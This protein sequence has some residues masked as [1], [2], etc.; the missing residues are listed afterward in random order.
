MT[1]RYDNRTLKAKLEPFNLLKEV[2][3]DEIRK[4]LT[5]ARNKVPKSARKP[6]NVIKIFNMLKSIDDITNKEVRIFMDKDRFEPYGKSTIEYYG[7]AVRYAAEHI[8]NLLSDNPQELPVPTRMEKF[9]QNKNER[10]E[11]KRMIDSLESKQALIDFIMN[12]K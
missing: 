5:E 11:L 4:I 10:K 8:D 6:L 9:M 7:N 12:S 2:E 3:S 1:L